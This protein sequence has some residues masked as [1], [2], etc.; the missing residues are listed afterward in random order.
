MTPFERIKQWAKTLNFDPAWQAK[1]DDQTS[2]QDLED[3]I[4]HLTAET[5]S[6][7]LSFL[8]KLM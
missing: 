8:L 4:C 5:G 2:I 1:V 3:M 6:L 7:N